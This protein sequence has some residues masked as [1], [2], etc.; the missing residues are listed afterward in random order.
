MFVLHIWLPIS[1]MSTK[2]FNLSFTHYLGPSSRLNHR[3][4]LEVD[5]IFTPKNPTRQ[6]ITDSKQKLSWLLNQSRDG[7]AWVELL[8]NTKI[9]KF[10]QMVLVFEYSLSLLRGQMCITIMRNCVWIQ[11][12]RN[13]PNN[14]KIRWYTQ[15]NSGW[16]FHK[17]T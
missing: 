10:K 13:W 1:E 8:S 2:L 11:A 4:I 15:V 12:N 3:W 7:A 16:L 5:D 9:L 17:K 14:I 6:T